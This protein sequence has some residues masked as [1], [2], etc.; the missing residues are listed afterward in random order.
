RAFATASTVASMQDQIKPDFVQSFSEVRFPGQIPSEFV[1]PEIL[2]GD[3]LS[4]EGEELRVVHLGRTDTASTTALHVPSIGLVVSGDAVYNNTHLI[5][6]NAMKMHGANGS[7]RWI[8]SRRCIR[9]WSW[10]AMASSTPI[11]PLV[12]SKKPD[13]TCRTSMLL[14]EVH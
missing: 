9:E 11:V 10:L 4:L 14:W 5:L 2:K 6:R 3:S 12:T 1:L 8:R 13:V 7:P